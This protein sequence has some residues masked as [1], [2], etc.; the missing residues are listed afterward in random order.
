MQVTGAEP[1]PRWL[2]WAFEFG[3]QSTKL[4]IRALG[5]VHKAG[6]STPVSQSTNLGFRFPGSSP[7]SWV[8]ELPGTSLQNWT[9]K[10]LEARSQSWAFEPQG[11]V[12]KAWAFEHQAQM[13]GSRLLKAGEK[14][15]FCP[16][17]KKKVTPPAKK[18]LM[19]LQIPARSS[20][21]P[22]KGQTSIHQPLFFILRASLSV[23][24]VHSFVSIYMYDRFITVSFFS[25]N[26]FFLRINVLHN[27]L[28][29]FIH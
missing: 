10:P 13:A 16:S 19:P 23:F 2:F 24:D 29:D 1:R 6:L 14:I 9:F 27:L 8:F 5:P 17:S 22:P 18:Q 3:N 11:A 21:P 26:K 28:F 4:G 25:S 12:Q 20:H 15:V 7:Q